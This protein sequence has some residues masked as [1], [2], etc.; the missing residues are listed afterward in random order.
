MLRGN[1]SLPQRG[2]TL[3]GSKLRGRGLISVVHAKNVCRV[4]RFTD[5]DFPCHEHGGLWKLVNARSWP[6]HMLL[7]STS[8]PSLFLSL[9]LARARSLDLSI[10]LCLFLSRSLDLSIDLV[11]SSISISSITTDRHTH[12][13]THT[14]TRSIEVFDSKISHTSA[15]ATVTTRIVNSSAT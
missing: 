6:R 3:E 15:H 7:S 11:S 4:P 1:H 12:T 10:S 8:F 2:E 13:H 5:L 9:S 14:H